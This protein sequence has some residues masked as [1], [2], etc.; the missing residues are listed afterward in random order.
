MVYQKISMIVA[1]GIESL[2]SSYI[3]AVWVGNVALPVHILLVAT[4][5]DLKLSQDFLCRNMDSL[6]GLG[7]VCSKT[8]PK[9]HCLPSK[10]NR[11]SVLS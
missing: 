1:K 6:K 5:S 7:R 2:T 3:H 8:V 9:S 10:L 4:T 11:E